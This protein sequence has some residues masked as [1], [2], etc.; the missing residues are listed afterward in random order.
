MNLFYSILIVYTA[1]KRYAIY[2]KHKVNISLKINDINYSLKRILNQSKKR[3]IFFYIVLLICKNQYIKLYI[4]STYLNK[5]SLN[6][7]LSIMKSVNNIKE[8]K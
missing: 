8:I 4:K 1:N 7:I 5:Q 2:L 6:Q 3:G